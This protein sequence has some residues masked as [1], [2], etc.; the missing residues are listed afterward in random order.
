MTPEHFKAIR[1]ELGLSQSQLAALLWPSKNPRS[2]ARRIR[3]WES[4]TPVPEPVQG[5][6][7]ILWRQANADP[8]TDDLEPSSTR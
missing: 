3:E 6:I 4:G 5:F 2:Q 8:P 1:T 7:N